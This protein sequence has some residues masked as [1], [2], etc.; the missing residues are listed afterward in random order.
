MAASTES[1][2]V[3]L[4]CLDLFPSGDWYRSNLY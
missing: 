1:V 4:T 2:K 3:S